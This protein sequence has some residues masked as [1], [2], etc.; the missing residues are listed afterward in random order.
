MIDA[1]GA[2]PPTSTELDEIAEFWLLLSSS[3]ATGDV[4]SQ[5]LLQ[6]TFGP[7]ASALFKAMAS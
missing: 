3:A 7:W 2:N 6:G 5:A 4:E 1:M